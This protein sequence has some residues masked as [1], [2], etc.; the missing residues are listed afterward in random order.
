MDFSSGNG[1]RQ[2]VSLA[3]PSLLKRQDDK[4]VATERERKTNQLKCR[5]LVQVASTKNQTTKQKQTNK[6]EAASFKLKMYSLHLQAHSC[7]AGDPT[8]LKMYAFCDSKHS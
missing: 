3:S 6:N 4:S 8:L 2:D 5:V 1:G 7:P